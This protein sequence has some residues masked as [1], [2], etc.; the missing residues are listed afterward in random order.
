MTIIIYERKMTKMKEDVKLHPECIICL[1][2]KYLGKEPVKLGLKERSEYYQA[3]LGIISQASLSMSAPEIVAEVSKLQKKMLGVE[4]DY[5]E[6]KKHFNSLMLSKE[7]IIEEKTA[8]SG[9]A[10][11]TAIQYALLGNYIDFGTLESVDES[12]LFELLDDASGMSFDESEYE[13]LKKDLSSAKELVYLTDNCG[14]IALDKLLIK[15]IK[16]DYPE[17]KVNAIVRGRAVLNDATLDD[18]LQV[19]LDGVAS[20][21]GNGS[22]I[23][24]TCLDRISSEAMDIIN[25]ADVVIA[26]GQGNFET[27][28]YCN[29]NVYYLFLCKCKMFAERFDVPR[30]SPMLLNDLRMK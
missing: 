19:G 13:N 12:K 1:T 23:A 10:L 15:Q 8:Q 21:C 3:V 5:T 4:D 9:D 29:K 2:N 11:L 26:K 30:F 7:S 17:I 25:S 6:I 27:M 14:E 22:D 20:V 24:G 18:A 16:K 28:R